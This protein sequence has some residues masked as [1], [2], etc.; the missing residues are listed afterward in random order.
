MTELRLPS[1]CEPGITARLFLQ[2]LLP[3]LFLLAPITAWGQTSPHTPFP[4]LHLGETLLNLPSPRTLTARQWEIRFAHRFSQP[5]NDGDVHSLWG[6]DSSADIGIGL[7]WGATD[8]LQLFVYR[9]D[10]LDDYELGA[11]LLIFEE[12]PAVPFSLAVRGG[13][14]IRTDPT[15]DN[16][17]SAFVQGIVS[18][19]FGDF[20]LFVIPSV[21]T[22]A[23]ID[24]DRRFDWVANVPIGIAWVFQPEWSLILELIPENRDLPEDLNSSIAWAA[25]IKRAVG[26][27]FFEIIL[28]NSRATHVDQYLTSTLLGSGLEGGDVHLG[29]NLERRFGGR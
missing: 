5:I 22:N 24:G 3:A 17:T 20:E 13:A 6:L 25:G 29:F 27:H 14:D 10:V 19:R 23:P 18:K 12:A 21:I 16:R 8:R 26:G 4:P 2:L 1:S 15:V 28:T 9:T 7:T 11:K